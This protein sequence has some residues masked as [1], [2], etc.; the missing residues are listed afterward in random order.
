MTEKV[1]V[2]PAAAQSRIASLQLDEL[3][4]G[5]P[6]VLSPD[7][8]FSGPVASV[9]ASLRAAAK[10]RGLRLRTRVTRVDGVEKLAIQAT[11][12]TESDASA[13]AAPDPGRR[14]DTST[15]KNKR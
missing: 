7:A 11:G 6:W 5:N 14:A 10:R 1:D 3:L 15:T 13:E 2:F 8:D 4:D 9:R 12:E